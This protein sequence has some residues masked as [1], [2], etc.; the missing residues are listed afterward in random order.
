VLCA[1]D[2]CYDADGQYQGWPHPCAS[3]TDFINEISEVGLY[4]ISIFQFV[5]DWLEFAGSTCEG[6]VQNTD[7]CDF[8]ASGYP[9]AG[10]MLGA[11]F[12]TAGE[13]GYYSET[14][15]DDSNNFCR[16]SDGKENYVV[17][18][19]FTDMFNP[20][21]DGTNWCVFD[22]QAVISYDEFC[23]N[24][25]L[26]TGKFLTLKD[27][28]VFDNPECPSSSKTAYEQYSTQKP[29]DWEPVM[30]VMN[31]MWGIFDNGGGADGEKNNYGCCK[32]L[33]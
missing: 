15:P 7:I 23:G 24:N 14:K 17:V 16:N 33:I 8:K 22:A 21:H 26:P 19:R 9:L 29:N 32:R 5:P 18:A 12:T 13:H 31:Y 10:F 2:S 1:G 6:P 3:A 20:Q 4:G 11:F 25:G 28:L 27:L 30:P